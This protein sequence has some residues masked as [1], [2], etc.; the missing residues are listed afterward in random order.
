MISFKQLIHSLRERLQSTDVDEPFVT[1]IQVAQESPEI[2]DTLL[3]ILEKPEFHRESLINTLIE[4]MRL[5][6][7]PPALISGIAELL[8]PKVAQKALE[9]LTSRLQR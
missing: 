8:N 6:G 2:G 7:A 1:L 5:K 9:L 4:E 3:S